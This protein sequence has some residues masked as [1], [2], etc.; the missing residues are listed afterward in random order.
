MV[1]RAPATAA[2]SRWKDGQLEADYRKPFDMLAVVV[3]AQNT[4]GEAI[5]KK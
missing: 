2:R 1:R 3:A 4:G 5:A